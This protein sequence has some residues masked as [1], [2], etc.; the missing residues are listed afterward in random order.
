M[1]AYARLL[2]KSTY[3]QKAITAHINKVFTEK[4][5][6]LDCREFVGKTASL[7]AQISRDN[8]WIGLEFFRWAVD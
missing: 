2:M 8:R 3:C 7:T 5:M 1:R 4:L 6:S